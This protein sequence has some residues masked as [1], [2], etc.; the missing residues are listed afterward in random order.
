VKQPGLTEALI[1][2]LLD[3]LQSLSRAQLGLVRVGKLGT[4]S[5]LP[6]LAVPSV[7]EIVKILEC[8]AA[9]GNYG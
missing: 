2:S 8:N 6:G 7:S 4:A 1:G 3:L 9:I 5:P